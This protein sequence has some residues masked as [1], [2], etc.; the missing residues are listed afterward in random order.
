[1]PSNLDLRFECEL[2]LLGPDLAGRFISLGPDAALDGY[3][4]TA[5]R[6]SAIR[7]CAHALS[8]RLMSD[9][10][11]D[12]LLGMYTM[13]LLST[14]QWQRLLGAHATGRL[15]DVGAGSGDVT[16]QLAPLFS[17]VCTTELSR[18]MA[19]VLR[20]RGF[21]C[22]LIDAAEVEPDATP[23]DV[24]ACLNVIDRCPYPRSL[25]ARLSRAVRDG[26][27]LVLAVPLPYTPHFYA[28]PTSL[29]PIETLP[30]ESRRWE[31]AARELSERVLAPLGLSV[32]SLCRAPYLS[33]GGRHRRFHVLD[34]AV[35]ICRRER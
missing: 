24:V 14:A 5:R 19:R 15:L 22:Q 33:S 17:Q 32:E 28:G 13:H 12:A 18:G 3:L 21:A 10:D 16:A 31:H 25:L 4:A 7:S 34:D 23:F 29:D 6:A 2:A 20:R 1:V 35:F 26:G 11:A 30:I 27:R 8:L 9:F